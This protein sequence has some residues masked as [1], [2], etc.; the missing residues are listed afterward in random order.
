[1]SHFT[2]KA[3]K[4]AG[5][6][7]MTPGSYPKDSH[8]R[9]TRFWAKYVVAGDTLYEELREER[10]RLLDEVKALTVDAMKSSRENGKLREQLAQSRLNCVSRE[11]RDEVPQFTPGHQSRLLEAVN[12]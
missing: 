6:S 5:I 7:E 4:L 1:M 10:D 11:I 3:R 2:E 8:Q 12:K 9:G